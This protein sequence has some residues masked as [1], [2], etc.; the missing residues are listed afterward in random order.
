[1]GTNNTI[2]L[3]EGMGLLEKMGL[4]DLLKR[5][6]EGLVA[7]VWPHCEVVIHDFSDLEHSAVVVAGNLS[8]RKPGAPVPDIDFISKD[9]ASDTPDQLNYKI[10]INSKEF[11]SSTVWIRDPK[12]KIVGAICINVDFSN[13]L[14]A[15]ALLNALTASA[16]ETPP[17]IIRDSLARDPDELIE[18]SVSS[19]LCQNGINNT[20]SMGQDE[21]IR[22]VEAFEKSGLFQFRGATQRLAEILK[23]SRATIYNYKSLIGPG[24]QK[25]K[26]RER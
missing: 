1:M 16:E 12:G 13:L 15:K 23:V 22:L 6:A 4:L 5:L 10:K 26:E 20:E 17:F 11:Q 8:G 18:L 24:P 7:V 2:C 14:K 3:G 25:D 19:F 9:L 21:R